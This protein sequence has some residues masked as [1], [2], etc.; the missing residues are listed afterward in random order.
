MKDIKKCVKRLVRK[1]GTRDPERLAKEMG[2]NVRYKQYGQITKGYYINLIRN[3]YIVI[4]SDLCY[5][6]RRIVLAHELGHA[7]LHHN[8]N[9]YFIREQ[10]LFP[11]GRYEVQANKF[12]AEL[13][14]DDDLID[15]N[16][17]QE[18][19]ID[20]ISGIYNVCRELIEYKFDLVV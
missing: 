6:E 15:I 4:N 8:H 9:I 5:E 18:Y 12:A 14:I 13:L 7:V 11:T 2:I 16:M 1:H 20:E 3:K 10:T 19:S 17:L